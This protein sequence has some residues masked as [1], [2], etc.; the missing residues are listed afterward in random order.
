MLLSEGSEC[1]VCILPLTEISSL[2]QEAAITVW[3]KLSPRSHVVAKCNYT[4]KK[5]RKV[6]QHAAVLEGQVLMQH[7]GSHLLDKHRNSA[8]CVLLNLRKKKKS[9]WSAIILS[10]TGEAKWRKPNRAGAKS[11]KQPDPLHKLP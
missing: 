6:S 8:G 2:I 11:G 4:G 7:A 1:V 5:K 9:G 3:R 10:N